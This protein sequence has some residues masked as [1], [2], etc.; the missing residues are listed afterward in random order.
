MPERYCTA[1]SFCFWIAGKGMTYIVTTAVLAIST[2]PSTFR[3]GQ[4][5]NSRGREPWP[6]I[7]AAS[8]ICW[9]CEERKLTLA[10]HHRC[11]TQDGSQDAPNPICEWRRIVHGVL[12]K[13][14]HLFMVA[15]DP[16]EQLAHD[17]EEG[18]QSGGDHGIRAMSVS[19]TLS[20]LM[21]KHSPQ[22]CDPLAPGSRKEEKQEKHEET[23]SRGE[24]QR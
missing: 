11:T 8:H 20:C 9:A 2:D 18:H 13:R 15:Q 4:I 6:S 1:I 22:S 16:I 12:P 23:V 7:L 5:S 3:V 21:G 17:N 19:K 10:A 24:A 14:R